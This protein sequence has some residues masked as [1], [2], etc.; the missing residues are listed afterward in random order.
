[1]CGTWR[2]VVGKKL[3]LLAGCG[4]PIAEPQPGRPPYYDVST[5]WRFQ[6]AMSAF[7]I[8]KSEIWEICVFKNMNE[9]NYNF[10][11]E[12]KPCSRNM[13]KQIRNP[14]KSTTLF[15][16]VIREAKFFMRN[17]S[18][19]LVKIFKQFCRTRSSISALT[20]TCQLS[21]SWVKYSILSPPAFSHLNSV[22]YISIVCEIFKLTLRCS[23]VIRSGGML[24]EVG[25]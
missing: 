6:G 25:L 20:R 4:L 17:C 21:L 18:T 7:K 13:L 5:K 9:S 10:Y 1:M 11:N 19:S 15:V 3:L 16:S 12:L 24:C 23:W 2:T 8:R 14:W 22:R